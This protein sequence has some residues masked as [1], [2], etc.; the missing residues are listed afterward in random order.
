MAGTAVLVVANVLQNAMIG[1]DTSLTGGLIGAGTVLGL[2]AVVAA[3]VFASQRVEKLVDGD[4]IV[5]ARNG[6]L[7]HD[8]LRREL[9]TQNEVLAA[10][11][12]AGISEL[13]DIR[14]A[15]L[16]SNGEI[17]VFG[18]SDAGGPPHGAAH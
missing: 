14:L 4:P 3:A 16:E 12:H 1:D 13:A 2:N 15:I 6:A 8:R 7:L 17:S 5:I 11:R 9:I 10:A 18:D